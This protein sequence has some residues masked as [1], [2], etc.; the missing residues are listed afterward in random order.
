MLTGVGRRPTEERDNGGLHTLQSEV[1]SLLVVVDLLENPEIEAPQS[2][3]GN[4]HNQYKINSLNINSI[5]R[6]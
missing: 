3:P 4:R 6:H 1:E 2:G 5:I